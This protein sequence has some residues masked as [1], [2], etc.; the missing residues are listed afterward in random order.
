[1]TG[2]FTL[3]ASNMGRQEPVQKL[4]GDAA[5]VVICVRWDDKTTA[6]RTQIRILKRVKKQ[7]KMRVLRPF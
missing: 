7:C 3:L 5:G 1:M 6:Y 4:F 2:R